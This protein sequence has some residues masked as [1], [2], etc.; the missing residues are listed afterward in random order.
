MVGMLRSSYGSLACTVHSSNIK[1]RRE[2]KKVNESVWTF[3]PSV[4][5]LNE[6]GIFFEHVRISHGMHALLCFCTFGTC[7]QDAAY[8]FLVLPIA[9]ESRTCLHFSVS[10]IARL[11]MLIMEC[12]CLFFFKVATVYLFSSP[13]LSCFTSEAK[14]VPRT[15]FEWMVWNECV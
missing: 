13:T 15:C 9:Y 11:W 8:E 6:C 14:C 5:K 4:F 12:V 2:R 1:Q 10:A 3:G 7:C